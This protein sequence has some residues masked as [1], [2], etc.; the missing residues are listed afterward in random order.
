MRTRNVI[1]L[2][3][4]AAIAIAS[5]LAGP[6]MSDVEQAKY[7]V[8]ESHGTIELR[9]Y[10]PLIAAEVEVTAP[11][12]E[13]ISQGFRMIADYI[14]G[15]NKE[16]GKVAMT[17][18]VIQQLGFAPEVKGAPKKLSKGQPA[19]DVKKAYDACGTWHVR[20]VMPASYTLATLPKPNNDAVK[21]SHVPAK[22]FAVIRFAGLAEND[23]LREHT[24][25]LTEFTKSKKLK[26]VGEPSYAFYNPPWTLSPLRRNEVMIEL[27]K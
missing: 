20:F 12:K 19:E 21:F 16:S 14:F 27:V 5:I 10:E 23:S 11:R 18:P 9:D 6:M 13:A 22:R 17:A 25:E 26:T 8:V 3:F 4:F 24:T 15:N 1:V 2:V 7:T